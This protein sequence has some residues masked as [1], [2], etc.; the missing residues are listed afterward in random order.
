MP[1]FAMVA[2]AFAISSGVTDSEP[3]VSDPVAVSGEVMP[4]R[5]ATSTTLSGP[6]ER[7]SRANAVFDET[8]K[9]SAMLF[10]P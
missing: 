6:I 5:L 2:Y 3:S 10:V 1:P 7:I 8:A 9:A 4:M